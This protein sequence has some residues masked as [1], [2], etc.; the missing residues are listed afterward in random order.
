[1]PTNPFDFNPKDVIAFILI[2]MRSAG[3]F[4]TA[5]VFASRNIPATVKASWVL[6][7]TFMIF[8]VVDFTPETLPGVGLPLGIAVVRELL[9][10]FSIGLGASLM[11]TGIQLAGQV[12]DIQMG[13]G[14]VNII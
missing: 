5:P 7:I 2:L 13:L 9:I 6:L 10:G 8:S 11:L 1:M 3:I 14:M 4:L 12:V